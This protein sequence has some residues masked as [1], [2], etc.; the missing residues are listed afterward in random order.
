MAESKSIW[1]PIGIIAG[2]LAVIAIIVGL[3]PD[4][5]LRNLWAKITAPSAPSRYST[6]RNADGTI[7][8][9]DSAENK[10]ELRNSRGEVITITSESNNELFKRYCLQ[11]YTQPYYY[12]LYYYYP[13]R[14]WRGGT[15]HHTHSGGT[16]GGTGGTM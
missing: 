10:C 3:F 9:T 13:V 14:W 7:A 1:R 15:W 6:T 2:I 16:D 8:T 11:G 5:W 12:Q 4:G